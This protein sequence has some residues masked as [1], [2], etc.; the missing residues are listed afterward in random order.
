[1]IRIRVLRRVSLAAAVAGCVLGN[2]LA[3][4]AGGTGSRDLSRGVRWVRSHPLT[5]MGLCLYDM[6]PLDAEQYRN[7]GFSA[8]LVWKVREEAI[9]QPSVDA[10]LPWHMHL[11]IGHHGRPPL[12]EETKQ[13]IRALHAKYPGGLGWLVNDEVKGEEPLR[14]TRKAMGWL[15]EEFP[16]MLVYS[17]ANPLKPGGRDD[18]FMRNWQSVLQPD[19][20]MFDLYPF[21]KDGGTLGD[22]FYNLGVVR[23]VALAAGIPY[24]TFIQSFAGRVGYPERL[25]SESDL[26]MQLFA[27]LTYGYTGLAYFIYEVRD[28]SQFRRALLSDGEPTRLYPHARKANAEV[29]R[30]GL[31]LRAL[32][33]TAVGY[34]AGLGRQ[35]PTGVTAWKPGDRIEGLEAVPSEG[36]PVPDILIG[37]FVDDSGGQYFMLTNLAHGARMSAQAGRAA[38]HVKLSHEAPALFRLSRETGVPEQVFPAGGGE[39]I[40]T[41]PGGTGDLFKWANAGFA[42]LAQADP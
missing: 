39:L 27:S 26:R 42:G 34:I 37:S 32:T 11:Y 40:V 28:H 12:N 33:S 5:L 8:I 17:N 19:V 3:A 2:G 14:I 4:A 31:S 30:V 7:A 18:R 29:A 22:Y 1:M 10:G 16:H 13:M 41:L 36:Q 15:R 21:T 25:P 35:L 20:L 9:L 24:W 38:L 6:P 23:E